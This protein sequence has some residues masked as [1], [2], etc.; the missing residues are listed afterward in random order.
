MLQRGLD[1]NSTGGHEGHQELDL[2]C[3]FVERVGKCLV[4]DLVTFD[5]LSI[6]TGWDGRS[7][8]LKSIEDLLLEC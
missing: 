7:G 4:D 5:D 1:R 2:A 6:G 8:T 3:S